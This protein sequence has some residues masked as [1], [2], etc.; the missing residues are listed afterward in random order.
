[1]FLYFNF[2]VNNDYLFKKDIKKAAAHILRHA[3]QPL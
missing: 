3:Q 1:M 2:Y